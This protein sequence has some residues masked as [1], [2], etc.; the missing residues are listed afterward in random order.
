MTMK[1]LQKIILGIVV[2]GSVLASM[3]FRGK[4]WEYTPIDSID[5]F[6]SQDLSLVR[7]L[8]GDLE[9]TL[10]VDVTAD[11]RPDF[12]LIFKGD[13]CF[14]RDGRSLNPVYQRISLETLKQKN[15]GI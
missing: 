7:S 12:L 15:I 3:Y 14:Y 6:T 1:T 11:G 13:N 10:H 5:S 8:L 9:K 4:Q 2:G